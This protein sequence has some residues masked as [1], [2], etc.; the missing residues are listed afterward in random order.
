MAA[1]AVAGLNRP[2][3]TLDASQALAPYRG[4]WNQRLAAHLLR[5]AGFGGSP[6]QQRAL[7]A[8]S[9][10][11]AVESLIHFS[12]SAGAPDDILS[13]WQQVVALRAAGDMARRAAMADIRKQERAS[14]RS[15]Q[16]WWLNQ[17]LTTASPLQE[18]MTLYFHGHFTT[19]AIEKGVYPDIVW[20]Q[21]QLF[22]SNALG[23]LRQLTLAV[24]QD[25]A[26]LL[27]LD[28]ARNNQSHP[29]ENYARELMELFTL[30][31]GNY[32]EQDVRESARAF[33]GWSIDY[34]TGQFVVRP[35]Q[36]DAGEKNFL[37]RT[38]YFDGSDIVN[39][40]YRQPAASRFWAQSLLGFFVY[41]DPEPE[42]IEA[43]AAQ[44]R[45]NDFNLAPVMSVLLQ[46]NVFFSERTYRALIKS[47]V[48]FVVGSHQAFGLQQI[49]PNAPRAL[50]AM[51]QVLFYPPNVAGWPGGE[52]WITSQ[53]I[54]ARQNFAAALVN[55]PMMQQSGWL[56]ET[57]ADAARAAETLLANI[58]Q[59]DAPPQA[60]SQLVGYLNGAGT[61]AL[62]TFS[63][64]NYQERV[65]GAAYLAMA[66]PAY[67]LN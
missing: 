18:K 29:N 47:P 45:K 32:T 67:Q 7:A 9:P 12:G 41:N 16:E 58:L 61:S 56:N 20:Q 51:G 24:S 2:A 6:G 5:R 50:A 13:P 21:N 63:G 23:N 42:L 28:N 65:R 52:N 1:A 53:T 25:P 54:I 26:M 40:I 57:P 35:R 37:G 38:G 60:T 44:I 10:H 17:M 64:E 19:A 30:G 46:S 48:E 33:T 14:I 8:M 55:A 22:R 49:Q 66:M 59:S 39:I 43:V 27:Y 3:G 31:R 15:M 36:H 11:A 34:K 4:P 62:G